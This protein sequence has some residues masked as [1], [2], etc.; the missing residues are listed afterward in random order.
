MPEGTKPNITYSQGNSD[1]YVNLEIYDLTK[2][3]VLEN[4]LPNDGLAVR[5]EIRN[6]STESKD[7]M[8]IMAQYE[9]DCMSSLKTLTNK[10]FYSGEEKIVVEEIPSS[11][12]SNETTKVVFFVWDNYNGLVP[13][14]KKYSLMKG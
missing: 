10:T 12:I 8:L 2:G 9:G 13:Y 4:N 7:I 6:S 1:L 5:F 14:Q 11:E 3:I